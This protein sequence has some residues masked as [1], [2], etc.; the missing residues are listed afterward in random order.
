MRVIST[1][2][3]LIFTIILIIKKLMVVNQLVEPCLYLVKSLL[4]DSIK[5][6]T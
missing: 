5:A 3:I 1:V 6:T 2:F 4:P